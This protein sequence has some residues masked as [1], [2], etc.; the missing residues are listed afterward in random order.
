LIALDNARGV[1]VKIDLAMKMVEPPQSPVAR[2]SG[3]SNGDR[4]LVA[5]QNS[6]RTLVKTQ[7]QLQQQQQQESTL[8]KQAATAN[9]GQ[10]QPRQQF[11]Q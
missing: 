9:S 4:T 2:T 3:E 11:P 5:T 8:Y 6:E 7:Q 1:S 10:Q